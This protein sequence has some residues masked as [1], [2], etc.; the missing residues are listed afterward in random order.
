MAQVTDPERILGFWFGRAAD[1]PAAAAAREPFWFGASTEA[2]SLVRDRF[3][4]A[5]E[6]AA[7]G[8]LESWLE[9]PR[10]ALALVLLLD[11]FPRNLWR[12]TARAF[13]QDA[14]ALRMAR[15]AVGRGHL[16]KLAPIEQAFL[17]LPYQHSESLEDQR[18][19]RRLS[20][21]IARAAPPAWHALLARYREF[22]EEH[23]A[24]IER[25]GRFPHRNRILGRAATPEEEA[26]LA[27]GGTS[28]GQE[29]MEPEGS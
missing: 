26:Y 21:E 2:D 23:L 18:E 10:S 29:P 8:E 22:A 24:L 6:A 19:S 13:G 12:G 9:A 16:P 11:Q 17:V 5:V 3:G 14:Q 20:S 15:T 27:G 28:F 1:D 25:F 7:R 4:S